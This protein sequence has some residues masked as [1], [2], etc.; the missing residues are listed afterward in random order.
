MVLNFDIQNVILSEHC[1]PLC[2][3]LWDVLWEKDLWSNLMRKEAYC[4]P[5]KMVL[6]HGREENAL[7]SPAVHVFPFFLS[8]L[9]RR[10][11]TTTIAWSLQEVISSKCLPSMNFWAYPGIMGKFSVLCFSLSPKTQ[12]RGLRPLRRGWWARWSKKVH[13]IGKEMHLTWR[14]SPWGMKGW[15]TFKMGGERRQRGRG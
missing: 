12:P 14:R 15:R 2:L 13:G 5:P 7:I 9:L 3:A 6:K 10:A 11:Y 8:Y 4:V 1:F